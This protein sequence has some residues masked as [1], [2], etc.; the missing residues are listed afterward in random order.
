MSAA[1]LASLE[2]A[3][4]RY[5]DHLRI[6]RRYAPG[7]ITNY[8]RELT[9]LARHAR[10]HG[11]HDW[12]GLPPV[13]LQGLMAS[14]HRR[15][16]G[17]GSLR[18]LASACRSFFQ[19]LI[20]EGTL[21]ANPAA[22]LRAPKLRRRL[23][24]VLDVDQAQRLVELDAEDPLVPRD[25]A[26]LELLYSSGLRVAE[27]CNVRWRDLDL[28]EGLVR[29][30]GKGNKTRVVPV[31]RRALAALRELRPTSEQADAPVFPGRGGKPLSPSALR[32]RLKQRASEQGIAQRV[33]PHLLRHTCASHLLESSGELRAVQEL[34]GHADIAT[35]EIYTHLDF[36]RLA[37]VY[38]RAH[39]R[40]RQR[41][42][43]R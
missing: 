36:Q 13:V 30:T 25:R 4:N 8:A 19:W 3:V 21:V 31:G 15:G 7:T 33:H 34:L 10:D 35:T 24:H 26:V 2:V 38:D 37:Q 28:D 17:P 20:R 39:P 11:V 40:A 18:H 32:L 16:R 23:P 29:V 22:G 27:L 43:P 9:L 12:S 6:A 1:D 41:R 14:E 42:M 5:L